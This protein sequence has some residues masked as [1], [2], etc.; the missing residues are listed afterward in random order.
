MEKHCLF[1]SSVNARN[2]KEK[3]TM[4]NPGES[5]LTEYRGKLLRRKKTRDRKSK[6]SVTCSRA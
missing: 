6:I 4:S 3:G 2:T 5:C 1:D